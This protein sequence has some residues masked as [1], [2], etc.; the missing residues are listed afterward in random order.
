MYR[1]LWGMAR[2]KRALTETEKNV[3]KIQIH[4]FSSLIIL[5]NEQNSERVDRHDAVQV[6]EDTEQVVAENGPDPAG[7]GR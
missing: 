6:H 4:F 1:L 5:T 2:H 3:N 7:S